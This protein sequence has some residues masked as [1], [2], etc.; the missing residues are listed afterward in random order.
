MIG[1][2]PVDDIPLLIISLA[3]SDDESSECSSDAESNY[4]LPLEKRRK[5]NNSLDSSSDLQTT[6]Y[7]DSNINAS[8]DTDSDVE[9]NTIEVI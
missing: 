9:T 8:A 3:E 6:N 2:F 1:N 5:L 7:N 4:D